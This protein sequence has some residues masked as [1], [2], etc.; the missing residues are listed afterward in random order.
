[1]MDI[2]VENKSIGEIEIGLFGNVV[3]RTV[4]NFRAICTG[5][6]GNNARG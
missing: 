5:E 3:P 4:E 6:K 2:E 1:M